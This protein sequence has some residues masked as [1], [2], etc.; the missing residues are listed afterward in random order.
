MCRWVR[1]ERPPAPAR[2]RGPVSWVTHSLS[3]GDPG[4][5][6]APRRRRPGLGLRGPVL[7]GLRWHAGLGSLAAARTLPWDRGPALPPP[8]P[9]GA[10]GAAQTFFLP[11]TVTRAGSGPDCGQLLRGPTRC[12]YTSSPQTVPSS[13][14]LHPGR[15]GVCVMCMMCVSCVCHV[16]CVCCVWCHGRP[17]HSLRLFVKMGPGPAQALPTERRAGRCWV[18]PRGGHQ[19]RAAM[20][21]LAG[22]GATRREGG[23]AT[24][25]LLSPAQASGHLGSSCVP[26][27]GLAGCRPAARNRNTIQDASCPG[28]GRPVC[29]LGRVTHPITARPY[30]AGVGVGRDCGTER[31]RAQGPA[32]L[33]RAHTACSCQFCGPHS[34]PGAS[35]LPAP[36]SR[37]DASGK[38][39]GI[40]LPPAFPTLILPQG[41]GDM[42]PLERPCPHASWYSVRLLANQGPS[43]W[44][45]SPTP[46]PAPEVLKGPRAVLMVDAVLGLGRRRGRQGTGSGERAARWCCWSERVLLFC[47]FCVF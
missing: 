5:S 20:E 19:G 33:F 22:D 44:S 37:S 34:L 21:A 32:Q 47:F 35:H 41:R 39:S 18:L 8:T 16:C 42:C 10:L 13:S 30:G 15:Q 27:R 12:P 6:H 46:T 17:P 28:C 2:G 24:Q 9:P 45:V 7:P 1:W 14:S 40:S 38:P 26:I 11:N 43:Q 23:S 29:R 31:P 3:P 4:R 25:Q 36:G